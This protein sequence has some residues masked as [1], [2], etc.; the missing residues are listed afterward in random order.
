MALPAADKIDERR[1]TQRSK[2][3]RGA[4]LVA[5]AALAL[6]CVV[7]VVC[8]SHDDR[9]GSSPTVELVQGGPGETG[10]RK[11][12]KICFG[13]VCATTSAAFA[14]VL[15]GTEEKIFAK[16][17]RRGIQTME[18]MEQHGTLLRVGQQQ[19]QQQQLR[20]VHHVEEAPTDALDRRLAHREREDSRTMEGAQ[21]SAKPTWHSEWH[22]IF[23]SRG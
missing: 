9:R 6:A 23:G 13:S 5:A 17:E 10:G 16:G 11:L 1:S 12:A 4:A 19:Q 21:H 20:R 3:A 22:H 14:K 15:E 8:L 18:Q 7:V 2:A